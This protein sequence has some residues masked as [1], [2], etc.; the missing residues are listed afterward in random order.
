MVFTYQNIT[1]YQENLNVKVILEMKILRYLRIINWNFIW[2]FYIF[3]RVIYENT[4]YSNVM[5]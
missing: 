2:Y 5:Y 1:F 3:I 4:D